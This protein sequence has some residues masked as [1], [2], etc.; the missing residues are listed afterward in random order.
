MRHQ[1]RLKS[2]H[3]QSEELVFCNGRTGFLIRG[4]QAAF[5]FGLFRKFFRISFVVFVFKKDF[6]TG[7]MN[8]PRNAVKV[9]GRE[10]GFEVLCQF[11]PH[12]G[13]PCAICR[14]FWF[15]SVA[16][17]LWASILISVLILSSFV[18]LWSFSPLKMVCKVH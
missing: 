3:Q 10:G 5:R 17:S 8:E 9:R 14:P 4:R 16:C 13:I 7:R 12:M 1:Q 18:I 15:F 11:L 2:R 6:F